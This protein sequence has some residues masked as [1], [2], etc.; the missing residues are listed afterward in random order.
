M[1]I[2]LKIEN[3]GKIKYPL[4]KMFLCLSCTEPDDPIL[5][6]KYPLPGVSELLRAH[7][8]DEKDEWSIMVRT[9]Q[10]ELVTLLFAN[11]NNDTCAFLKNLKR[12]LMDE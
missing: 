9:D 8:K 2:L 1:Q 5:T 11:L 10:L 6:I 4:L 7:F 3:N 12:L